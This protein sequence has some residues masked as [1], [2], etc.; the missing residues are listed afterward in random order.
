[1]ILILSIAGATLHLV[2]PAYAQTG[3]MGVTTSAANLRTGPGR[4]YP[5]ILGIPPNTAITLEARNAASTWLLGR[6]S[7]GIRGWLLVQQIN[8]DGKI[9]SLPVS[10]E[11]VDPN[12][13]LAPLP[14]ELPAAQDSTVANDA[15]GV[16]GNA[17]A[18]RDPVVF[19]AKVTPAV[20]GAMRS[21][22]QRG[23]AM[24]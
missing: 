10:D 11:V 2:T 6:T 3:N 12:V 16:P 19:A 18:T 20:Q 24:G 15:D 9:A 14:T 22:Y 13:A 23:L 7:H 8:F 1:M 5:T 21:V 4:T 17:A